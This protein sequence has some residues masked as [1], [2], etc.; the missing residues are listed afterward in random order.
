MLSVARRPISLGPLFT[1]SLAALIYLMVMKVHTASI[2]ALA[3]VSC[4]LDS[5]GRNAGRE[6]NNR[7]LTREYS[8]KDATV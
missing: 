3:P 7:N 4:S 1:L 5:T 6:T 8:V 2:S